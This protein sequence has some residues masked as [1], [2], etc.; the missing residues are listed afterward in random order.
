MKSALEGFGMAESV[1]DKL[2]QNKQQQSTMERMQQFHQHLNQVSANPTPQAIAKLSVAY[3]EFAD[4]L[5]EPFSQLDTTQRQAKLETYF[6]VAAAIKNDDIPVAIKHLENIE[7]ASR[8]SGDEHGAGV[9]RA[10]IDSL[11]M[12]P[13][14]GK[15]TINSVMAGLMGPD[16]YAQAMDLL[17]KSDIEQQKAPVDIANT[18]AQTDL[19]E[20][21]AVN[22]P[23]K[24]AL[25]NEKTAN[26]IETAK[27]ERKMKV[28]DAQ[29]NSDK[30]G[31]DK[32]RL[33]VEKDK[34]AQE[35]QLKQEAA[36][37]TP[38]EKAQTAM[39]GSVLA[40]DFL[41]KAIT[42]P[43]LEKATGLFGSVRRLFSGSDASNFEALIQTVESDQFK[44]NI[45]FMV[46]MGALSDAEG[47][48]I[49]T[50][51]GSLA[52]QQDG[53]VFKKNLEYMA[54][55][56]EK[57]QAGL[58]ARGKLPQEGG[59]FVMDHPKFGKIT[60]GVINKMLMQ[61]PGLTRDQLIQQ[62]QSKGGADSGY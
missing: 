57:A 49:I 23:E 1:F 25:E 32:E 11:N 12:H 4:K 51:G 19:K 59:A 30:Y 54:K 22:Y 42:H 60:E 27:L 44:E 29:L 50:M 37:G 24:S 47:R 43:G 33:Q 18:K 5:K 35:L 17:N 14:G 38:A 13:V 34:V 52:M 53:P 36:G 21:E 55:T 61:K 46:G 40:L 10:T 2:E 31:L 9:A 8:N 28:I 62:L 3:P 41:N 6:P 16:K 15:L 20:Q 48:Q 26:D 58:I 39:D 7:Q 56:I 45:H